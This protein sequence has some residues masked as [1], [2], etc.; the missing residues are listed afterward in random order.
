MCMYR[1]I[2][3]KLKT[4]KE[5]KNKKPLIIKG[6][7]QVGKTYSIREFAKKNYETFIEINF[8]REKEYIEL[9]N[10]TSKPSE[11]ISYI[12]LSNMGKKFNEKS[13]LIFFDEIQAC[14]NALTAL[15]FLS[16]ECPY[17]IICSGSMLGI[18]IAS[19]SSFPVGYVDMW[20]MHP[21][22]FEEFLIAYG[23]NQNHLSLLHACVKEL[24]PLDAMIHE[25]FNELFTEYILCGGMP[26]VVMTYINTNSYSKALEVQRRIVRDYHNDMAK[27]ASN[28]DKLKVIECFSSL[29][30]QLAKENKKFQ[31]KVV[32]EGYNARYYDTSLRWL[33]ESGLIIKVNRL[34]CISTPLEAYAELPIFKIYMFDTGLLL[35]QFDEG[36]IKQVV[37]GEMNV[38]KGVLYEN[39]GAQIFNNH[40]KKCYYYEPNTSAE[41]DFIFYYEGNITPLEIKSGIHSRS[42][43]FSN[44]VAEYKPQKAYRFSKKNIGTDDKGILYLPYYLLPFILD[45]EQK[46]Y[47]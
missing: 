38:Y 2:D 7:R 22:D 37:S 11:I 3:N 4:W 9:F 19:S 14:G 18:A 6:A 42:T 30:L 36:A 47:I 31:Y 41:I 40:Q 28:S 33:E 24:R 20:D 46:N 35:S 39:I 16:E 13:T 12:Q 10:K 23:I 43:S 34:K 25:K 26:E 1:N 27:Y 5:Q 45:N 32:K 29:P 44:F 8:E 21:M 15:K 17:D